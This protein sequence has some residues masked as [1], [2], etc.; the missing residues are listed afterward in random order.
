MAINLP[1]LFQGNMLFLT[2]FVLFC[3]FGLIFLALNIHLLVVGKRF[4]MLMRGV[5]GENLEQL[6]QSNLEATQIAEARIDHLE[7]FT[8]HLE[9]LTA[10]TLQKVGFLRFNAFAEGGN[11]LS[12]ALAL[13]NQ[14]A[15]G[16]VLCCLMNRD[17]CRIYGKPVVAGTSTYTL[18][19][20]EQIAITRAMHPG[21]N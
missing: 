20:E 15:D 5:Q 9:D 8:G 13:L 21:E 3:L 18:S 7:E 10:S 4:K 14:K 16:I 2:V 19:Q 12:F 6:L 17:D 1:A 11:Q